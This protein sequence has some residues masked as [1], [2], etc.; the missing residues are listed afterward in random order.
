TFRTWGGPRLRLG[1]NLR[2]GSNPA[3]QG[4]PPRRAGRA[5][6]TTAF[7]G[8][9]LLGSTAAAVLRRSSSS[10]H[11]TTR[12]AGPSSVRWCERLRLP[13]KVTKEVE[14]WRASG[15]ASLTLVDAQHQTGGV[16]KPAETR[17]NDDDLRPFIRH[18]V[19]AASDTRRFSQNRASTI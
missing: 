7:R 12:R 11:N 10:P 3:D 9:T 5:R 17:A 4:A 14:C 1:H 13:T 2:L 19:L 15:R 16:E 6:R 8:E 18:V